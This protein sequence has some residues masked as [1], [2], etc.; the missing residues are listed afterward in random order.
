MWNNFQGGSEDEKA[1][2]RQLAK[3]V[4]KKLLKST[5]H[6][7]SSLPKVTA[8]Q[9][10]FVRRS[11]GSGKETQKPR[12]YFLKYLCVYISKLHQLQIPQF[13]GFEGNL[14]V[15]DCTVNKTTTFTP[16]VVG[17]KWHV[18][19]TLFWDDD[20]V[21]RQTEQQ[22]KSK[23]RRNRLISSK[24]IQ[25][26]THTHIHT[27]KKKEKK[28]NRFR[29]KFGCSSARWVVVELLLTVGQHNIESLK[30]TKTTKIEKWQ[31]IQ[32][33]IGKALQ[34]IPNEDAKKAFC[35]KTT[36]S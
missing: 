33:A 14:I 5:T 24:S 1:N 2:R 7:T 11:V 13:T 20:D 29:I 8:E 25:P 19:H 4:D 23:K 3:K 10:L 17:C 30:A 32:M 18:A 26:H 16:T 36:S 15:N 22:V 21:H 34:K 31:W 12:K 28:R 35:C 9:M 27:D 6:I